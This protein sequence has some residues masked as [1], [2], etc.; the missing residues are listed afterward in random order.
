MAQALLDLRYYKCGHCSQKF[1]SLATFGKHQKEQHTPAGAPSFRGH[2]PKRKAE[3]CPV[4]ERQTEIYP[5]EERQS[6]A[7]PV[8]E[9]ELVFPTV[10][11]AKIQ[12]AVEFKLCRDC[13]ER[14]G[15]LS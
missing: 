7:C 8:E 14:N 2:P 9:K 12:Y 1:K 5:V 11:K 13:V 3:V 6:N 15:F 10:R 4:E